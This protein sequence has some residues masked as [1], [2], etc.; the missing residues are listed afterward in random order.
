MINVF[1]LLLKSSCRVYISWFGLQTLGVSYTCIILFKI[2]LFSLLLYCVLPPMSL[3]QC[4]FLMVPRF[5]SCCFVRLALILIKLVSIL[6][7]LVYYDRLGK[8]HVNLVHVKYC[9]TLL[10]PLLNSIS[11]RTMIDLQGKNIKSL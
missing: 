11:I 3:K 1:L 6:V 7:S 10:V 8:I 9:T 5:V 2:V 4:T